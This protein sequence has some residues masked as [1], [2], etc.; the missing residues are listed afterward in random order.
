MHSTWIHS[1]SAPLASTSSHP[2]SSS[3]LPSSLPIFLAL[4]PQPWLSALSPLPPSRVAVGVMMKRCHDADPTDA[5][6]AVSQWDAWT[7]WLYVLA[8]A[9]FNAGYF[10]YVKAQV[11][12]PRRALLLSPN[13]APLWIASTF[14]PRT[15]PAAPYLPLQ[16]TYSHDITSHAGLESG[17]LACH[18]VRFPPNAAQAHTSSSSDLPMSQ[19]TKAARATATKLACTYILHQVVPIS[20]TSRACILD[21]CAQRSSSRSR[22]RSGYSSD[23]PRASPSPTCARGA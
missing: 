18:I 9:V 7:L 2:P 11:S 1:A 13:L 3:Q 4:P 20:L 21:R 10:A 16:V 19:P 15:Q 6:D 8:L 23:A 22:I 17:W 14:Y 5:C 12:Q